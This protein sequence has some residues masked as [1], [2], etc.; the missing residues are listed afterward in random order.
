MPRVDSVIFCC[1]VTRN[2]GNFLNLHKVFQTFSLPSVPFGLEFRVVVLLSDLQ[3][4]ARHRLWLAFR[5][6]N[7]PVKLEGQERVSAQIEAGPTEFFELTINLGFPVDAF[8]TYELALSFD[9]ETRIAHRAKCYFPE[10]HSV[11]HWMESAARH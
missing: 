8:G 11:P 1:A 6:P 10:G 9:Q 2:E 5:G 7:G 4:G 3:L